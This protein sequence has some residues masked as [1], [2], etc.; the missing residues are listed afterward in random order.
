MVGGALNPGS[1][2]AS[3]PCLSS[4]AANP[5]GWTYATEAFVQ[6]TVIPAL[7]EVLAT[8]PQARQ[9]W[10]SLAQAMA[11]C[12]TATL[13]IEGAKVKAT[14]RPLPFPRIASTS[15]AYAWGFTISGLQIGLDLLLFETGTYAG[16]LTY[17]DLGPPAAATVRA[18]AGAAAAKAETG[19][20]APVP[21]AVSIASAPVRTAHTSLGTVAYRMVGSGPPLVMITGYSG[22]MEGGTVA[23]STP[24]PG[25]TGS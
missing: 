7:T 17:S 12:Q 23:S 10:Q 16:Y 15:S 4:L 6:G 18:F 20:T 14:V 11:R 9:R 24:S 2:Q 13:T 21:D 5:K 8:G 3:A 22:T 1:V 25:T 19:S